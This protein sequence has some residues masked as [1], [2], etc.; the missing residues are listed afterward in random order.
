MATKKRRKR[1]LKIKRIITLFITLF[2]ITTTLL[3]LNNIKLLYLSKTTKYEIDTIEVFL[4]KDIFETVKSQKYSKTLEKAIESNYYEDAYLNEY[5]DIKYY[6][7]TNFI[8]NINKLLKIG[9]NSERINDIYS[10]LNDESIQ[11]LFDNDYIEDINNII[12]LNYFEEQNLD[13]YIKYYNKSKLSSED[14]VTYVNIGLDNKYYTN[15]K[16][17]QEEDS[18]TA[19]VNKYHS[20][21]SNYIPK[22]LENVKYG[23]GKLKDVAKDAFDKMCEAARKDKIYIQGGS[24]YRSYEYQNTLYNNYV[25]RDGFNAAETYSARPGYSEHQTGLAMDVKN[26][27]GEF[28]SE[29]DKEYKWLINNS[30]KYGFI[31]RYPKG[32]DKLTG[33]MY[34]EWH[35]RY[36]G[37]DVATKVYESGL[38]YDEFVARNLF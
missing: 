17:I 10:I 22:N 12:K 35:Y 18:L 38:T 26:E 21:S 36:L 9:Y 11:I 1:K 13:R 16:K 29:S 6:D 34:E 31:L 5:L 30:Y 3:N 7:K 33:Y 4:E 23:T 2:I 19:I 14:T 8:E 15:I 32:K 28:I 25:A 20:L 27:R 37:I 24:G